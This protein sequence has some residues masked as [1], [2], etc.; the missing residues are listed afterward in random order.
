TAVMTESDIRGHATVEG[1][2]MPE[3]RLVAANVYLGAR[4][5]ADALALGADVVVVGRC[6]DPALALGPL[7]HEFGWSLDDFD[8]IAAGT[9]AGHL[10]ECGAQV[11]GGYFADP[12]YKDVPDFAR[13]GFPI[14]EID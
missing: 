14:A 5:I 8:R 4:P 7:L 2:G 3:G 13:V 10:L 12:G 11:T 6:A 1:I 9:M